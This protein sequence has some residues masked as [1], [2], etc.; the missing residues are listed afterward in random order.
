M[1]E[2][3]PM[4]ADARRNRLRVL[5]VAAQVF[6]AEGL[7]VPVHEIAR[8][9]GVGTGTV[10]RHFPTKEALFEAIL[11]QETARLVE[12][13]DALAEHES[14]GTAFY[15]FFAAVIRAGAADR[16]LAER[17]AAA[18]N[19]DGLDQRV[20]TDVLC[21]RLDGLLSNAQQAGAVR[22]GVTLADVE[23]LMVACM[24]RPDGAETVTAV[25]TAGLHPPSAP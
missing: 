16:G 3:R 4:R 15:A 17:L 11:R 1:T 7:S 10:T 8:R 21:E 22:T 25:V 13:A 5:E 23:A 6:A 12:L 9:A 18:L 20:G 14:P 2:P 24:S 19:H